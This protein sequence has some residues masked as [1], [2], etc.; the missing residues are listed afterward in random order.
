MAGFIK[1][2]NKI[3]EPIVSSG[4]RHAMCVGETGCGKTSSFILPNLKDRMQKNHGIFVLDYK[5]VLHLQI[6]ALAKKMGRLQDI[7][8]IG[9]PWGDAINI[10]KNVNKNLF[11]ESI[12]LLNGDDIDAFWTNSALN[13]FDNISEAYTLKKHINFLA[14]D[15]D[16]FIDDAYEFCVKDFIDSLQNKTSL[17]EFNSSLESFIMRFDEI[18]LITKATEENKQSI[19]LI[20]SYI[21]KLKE[22]HKKFDNLCESMDDDKPASGSYGVVFQALN[23]IMTLKSSCLNGEEDILD[24]LL[25]GKIIIFRNDDFSPRTSLPVMNIIYKRLTKRYDVSRPISLFIDEFQRSITKQT[26]PHVDVFREKKVELIAAMQNYEQLKSVAGESETEAFMQNIIEVYEYQQKTFIYKKD[27]NSFKA[28]PIF[29]SQKELD[30]AQESWQNTLEKRKRL[31]KDWIYIE[32]KDNYTCFIKNLKTGE[33]ATHFYPYKPDEEF[34]KEVKKRLKLKEHY[35]TN[36]EEDEFEKIIKD[37]E[38]Y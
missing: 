23:T 4:F 29:F 18:R 27:E 35:L 6:K 8:E 22:L 32:A 31:P 21:Q 26:L 28:K 37:V 16:M 7:V 14:K 15:I 3:V 2:E 11:L 30:L 5:G 17:N 24:L 10:I 12:D 36:E 34:E 13:W 9:S 25:G 1:E 20:R 19:L 38:N 33:I